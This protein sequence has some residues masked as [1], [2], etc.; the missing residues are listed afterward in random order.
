MSSDAAR[1]NGML[2]VRRLQPAKDL[3]RA[4]VV[5]NRPENEHCRSIM[6]MRLVSSVDG[7][8]IP[9]TARLDYLVIR[10]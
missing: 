1:I 3:E 9:V 2:V 7:Y 4:S 8:V 5:A 10:P 6:T